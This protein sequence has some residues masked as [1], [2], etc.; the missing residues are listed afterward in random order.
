[1]KDKIR[2]IYSEL[3]GYLTEA[4]DVKSNGEVLYDKPAFWNQYNSTIDELNKI[5]DQDYNRYKI[6]TVTVPWQTR[7]RQAMD[8]QTYRT[9][10]GGLIS[11]LYGTYFSDEAP[12]FSGMPQTII[13]Q[14]Q[15]QNQTVN[16]LLE[17]QSKIDEK[18]PNL[19]EGTEKTFLQKVKSA[20]SGIS[21]VTGL[22]GLL[23]KTANDLGLTTTQIYNLFK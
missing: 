14:N 15:N 3:Q 22:I 8:I 16:L 17:I 12:P 10:L 9:K 2:P 7:S 13:N 5:A 11:R 20:L 19:P 18:L 4:P 21:S 6:E 23:L 1:M